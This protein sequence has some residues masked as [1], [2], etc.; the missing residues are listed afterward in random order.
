MNEETNSESWEGR[1]VLFHGKSAYYGAISPFR[2]AKQTK[3]Q[4][5]ADKHGQKLSIGSEECQ[6]GAMKPVCF[7]TLHTFPWIFLVV[8]TSRA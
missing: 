2:E 3:S 7:Q 6:H 8:L 1:T 4:A 5:P